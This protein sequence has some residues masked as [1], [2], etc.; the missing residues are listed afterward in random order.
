MIVDAPIDASQ[1]LITKSHLRA[2][3]DTRK[4]ALIKTRLNPAKIKDD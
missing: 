3:V 4:S 2:S 1:I